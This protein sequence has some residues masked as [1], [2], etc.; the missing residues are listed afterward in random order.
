MSYSLPPGIAFGK[1][2]GAYIRALEI[3]N[4]P[5][6]STAPVNA[7]MKE[8]Q[9]A[10]LAAFIEGVKAWAR[11]G[12][13]VPWYIAYLRTQQ[14]CHN[15]AGFIQEH[16]ELSLAQEAALMAAQRGVNVLVYSRETA[17]RPQEPAPKRKRQGR[18]K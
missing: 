5:G 17:P 16:G 1:E 9:G 6:L 8:L 2:L 14:M 15:P 12:E 13:E 18:R 4:G 10:E 11:F 3:L 7:A